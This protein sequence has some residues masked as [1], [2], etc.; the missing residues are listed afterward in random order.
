M[1]AGLEEGV[2]SVCHGY[3]GILLY[4]KLI[5]CSSF[6]EMYAGLE[7]GMSAFSICSFFYM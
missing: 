4:V 2:G 6:P 7:R 3:M 1:Y 5:V